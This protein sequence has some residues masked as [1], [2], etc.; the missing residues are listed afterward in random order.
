M[1][2]RERLTNANDDDE[3]VTGPLG[4]LDKDKPDVEA[5]PTPKRRRWLRICMIIL[6]IVALLVGGGV[7]AGALYLR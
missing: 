5:P 6:G 7:T 4:F 1:P 2:T 3:A